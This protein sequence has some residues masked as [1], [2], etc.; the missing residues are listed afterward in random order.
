MFIVE[1]SE[2]EARRLPEILARGAPRASIAAR[3]KIDSFAPLVH[4]E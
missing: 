1:G 2:C 3:A 4:L